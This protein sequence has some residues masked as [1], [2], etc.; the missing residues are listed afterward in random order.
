MIGLLILVVVIALVMWLIE[1]LPL[2]EPWRTVV[3]VVA[4]LVVIVYLLRLAGFGGL[5]PS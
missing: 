1:S 3:R 4:V 2:A 5:W